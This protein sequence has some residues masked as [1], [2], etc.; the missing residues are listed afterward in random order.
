[1]PSAKQH[2]EKILQGRSFQGQRKFKQAE[3]CFKSVLREDPKHVDALH[4]MGLL[5]IQSGKPAV[6]CK[7]LHA[8]LDQKP[9]DPA[10]LQ[11]IGAG[12][13]MQGKARQAL[14]YLHQALKFRD[15][16]VEV[17]TNLG[18]AYR[19]LGTT[20]EAIRYFTMALELDPGFIRAQL[21]L[22]GAL[23]ETG[24][25]TEAVELYRDILNRD[26]FNV[27]A[28]CGV[29]KAKLFK[30]D[31]PELGWITSLLANN[32]LDVK[33]KTSLHHAAGKIY[34]D[35]KQYDDAFEHL[36][37]SKQTGHR[38]F[39][40]QYHK[41]VYQRLVENTAGDS[42]FWHNDSGVQSDVPVFIV[43]IPRSG[44]TLVEQIIA[45]HPDAHGAGELP[46]MRRTGGILGFRQ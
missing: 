4:Q 1:M 16:S 34:N 31:D 11:N 2:A 6:G 45:S 9:N 8:A 21:G 44:T 12:S 13:I 30:I 26:K 15:D 27:E 40:I 14:S 28:L 7:Y 10:I 35:I 25:S 24:K 19:K 41:S 39:P 3:L 18:I 17:V 23:V 33:S 43:G 46:D 36:S 38:V 20:D 22:A 5:A 32:E 42:V 37:K 29:S